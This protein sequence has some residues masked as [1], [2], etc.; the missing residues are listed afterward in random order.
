MAVTTHTEKDGIVYLHTH[1]GESSREIAEALTPYVGRT[2]YADVPNNYGHYQRV[3]VE[4]RAV[5][6]TD[7]TVYYAR[8]DYTATVDA[9]DAF[10]THSTMILPEGK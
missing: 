8:T 5:N 9:F 10:G 1:H 6:G 3:R 4:L 7:A 2:V